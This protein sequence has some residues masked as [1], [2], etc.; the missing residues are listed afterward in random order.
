MYM[1]MRFKSMSSFN[2]GI[3]YIAIQKRLGQNQHACAQSDDS[4]QPDQSNGYGYYIWCL[5]NNAC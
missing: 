3:Y 1:L 5:L 2:Y 4:S